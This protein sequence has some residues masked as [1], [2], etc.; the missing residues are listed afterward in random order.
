[1][2]TAYRLSNVC[3]SVYKTGN[4]TFTPDGKKV[5]SPVGNRLSVT[6]LVA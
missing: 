3:G 2:A 4:L 1:M 6:D 5:I